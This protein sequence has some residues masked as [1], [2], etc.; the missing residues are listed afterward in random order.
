MIS[1]VKIGKN[2]RAKREDRFMTQDQ[3]AEAT[4]LNRDTLSRIE[5]NTVEPRF[6]TIMKL[7]REL[8]VDPHELVD[9]EEE[10][11]D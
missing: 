4:G 3:L 7:A 10:D 8:G 11:E 6:S 2:L 9:E 1:V 5:R